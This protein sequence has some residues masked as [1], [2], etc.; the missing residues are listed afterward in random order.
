MSESRGLSQ[1]LPGEPRGDCD[2][3]HPELIKLIPEM[4]QLEEGTESSVPRGAG[5]V[6][7]SLGA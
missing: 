6:A 1:I 4:V 3:P 7:P 5:G 2:R